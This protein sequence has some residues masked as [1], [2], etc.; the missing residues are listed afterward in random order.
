MAIAFL[1]RQHI[2][3]ITHIPVSLETF[4][5]ISIESALVLPD[6]ESG[7]VRTS[8]PLSFIKKAA[9]IIFSSSTPRGGASSTAISFLPSFPL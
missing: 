9:S 3:G 5:A 4:S 8:T 1:S 6:G 2:C 7:N